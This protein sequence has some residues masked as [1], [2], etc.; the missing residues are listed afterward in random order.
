M[1]IKNWVSTFTVKFTTALL[2]VIFVSAPTVSMAESTTIRLTPLMDGIGA[3]FQDG[4]ND[5]AGQFTTGVQ[6]RI[7]D[8]VGNSGNPIL[9]GATE[10]IA[11]VAGSVL[12]CFAGS[13]ISGL[14]GAGQALIAVPTSD[15][16][17]QMATG[18]NFGKECIM[19][20]IGFQLKE[21]LIKGVLKGMVT[22][23]NN[24][25][26]GGPGYLQNES[27]YF[28]DLK[29]KQFEDFVNDPKNFSSLCSAWESD[30]RLAL[31]TQYSTSIGGSRVT[32]ISGTGTGTG[33]QLPTGGPESCRLAGDGYDSPDA[34]YDDY[35]S[36]FLTQTTS[37]GGNA[38]TSFFSVQDRFNDTLEEAVTQKTNEIQRNGGFFD[39]VQCSNDTSAYNSSPG[40]Y[41]VGDQSCRITTPGTV[42]NEQLNLALGS[43]IRRL[44]LADEFDEVFSALVG[45]LLKTVFSGSGIFGLSSRAGGSQSIIDQYSGDTNTAYN[46]QTRDDL[47][48]LLGNY[49]EG[50]Q[51]HIDLKKESMTAL[52]TARESLLEAHQC[53]L[54]KYNTWV[55]K[56]N[57]QV[58][59]SGNVTQVPESDRER[60]SYFKNTAIGGPEGGSTQTFLLPADSK[61]R[62]DEYSDIIDEIDGYIDSL[63]IDISSVQLDISEARI[64]EIQMGAI[65]DSTD[66]LSAA[67]ANSAV[68]A[69]I[70]SEFEGSANLV[71]VQLEDGTYVQIPQDLSTD[72]ILQVYTVALEELTIHDSQAALMQRD[73]VTGAAEDMVQ[74]MPN[75]AGVRAPGVQDD[76]ESCQAFSQVKPKNTDTA[77]GN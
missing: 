74:G 23:I 70:A 32:Q 65:N 26:K 62:V 37:T 28:R 5:M 22:Y 54:S 63:Q 52:F 9:D 71:T 46:V 69:R 31:A 53:Y 29:D 38:L 17:V 48:T 14:L 58:I 18:G 59:S 75:S 10:A 27:T 76:I 13:A 36:D 16:S 30:V 42:I 15:F 55:Y 56:S 4:I 66:P 20:G 64:L 41:T 73:V 61:N 8:S 50:A 57:G 12:S 72:Q 3:G 68:L 77:G 45:Q 39:V 24:G 43:D 11:G 25:F 21:A 60:T 6:D 7:N 34:P 33:A 67:L 51:T 19:D 44:E 40:Q 2:M 35:W 47:L 1:K 49:K